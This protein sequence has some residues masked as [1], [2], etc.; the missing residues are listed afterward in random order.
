MIFLFKAFILKYKYFLLGGI[1]LLFIIPL[2][3]INHSSRH[4]EPVIVAAKES[5]I[6]EDDESSL[7]TVSVDIKGAVKNPGVYKVVKEAIVN[8]VIAY[9]GGLTNNATTSNINL[10][11][12]VSDEMVIYVYTKDELNKKKEEVKTVENK[13]PECIT[14]QNTPDISLCTDDK[15]SSIIV[16]PSDDNNV[17]STTEEEKQENSLININTASK[18]ELMS[19]SGIGESK[20]LSII[21]YRNNNGSFKCIEDI[22]NISGIGDALF[23][24]IKDSITV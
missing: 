15:E 1:F 20:A 9:A 6:K 18:E 5:I 19:L 14:K 11:K 22:K 13:T 4:K 21:E 7:E 24:K 3:I 23:E 12:K 10:S 16:T 8:D 2:I 17:N